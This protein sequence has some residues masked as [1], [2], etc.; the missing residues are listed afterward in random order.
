[1]ELTISKK[2]KIKHK[3]IVY[4]KKKK[5]RPFKMVY[6]FFFLIAI[7]S[8]VYG[9]LI[10]TSTNYINFDKC[11]I[12]F[13]LTFVI[14]IVFRALTLNF[15]RHWIHSRINEKMW[16]ENDVLNHFFQISWGSGWN[17][18]SVDNT[19]YLFEIDLNSV[20]QVFFDKETK[21]VE[22]L[23]LGKGNH[24]AD[25]ATG[26]IDKQWDLKQGY[27]CIL[28]DYYEPSIVKSLSEKGIPIID[29]QLN[30]FSILDNKI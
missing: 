9:V 8:L 4:T 26:R 27:K 11:A 15:T 3:E 6:H 30:D 5:W 21:R 24:Y 1:M 2:K 17:S 10:V 14:G 23:A 25:I 20:N 13:A 28:Y 22:F 7:C 29:E 18:R 19:G 12:V 16:I